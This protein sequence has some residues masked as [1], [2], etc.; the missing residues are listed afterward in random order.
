MVL[1][2]TNFPFIA[3]TEQGKLDSYFTELYGLENKGV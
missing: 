3:K 1:F 2:V